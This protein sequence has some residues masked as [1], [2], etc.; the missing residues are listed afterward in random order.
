MTT[1]TSGV[2]DEEIGSDGRDV[3]HSF[4]LWRGTKPFCANLHWPT[5]SFPVWD[6][7][8]MDGQAL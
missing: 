1:D 7:Y 8:A 5:F 3:G 2:S 6:I 4:R